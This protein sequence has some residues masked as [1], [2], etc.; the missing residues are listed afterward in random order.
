MASVDTN[1]LL[2]WILND[3]PEQSQ[4]VDRLFDSGQQFVVEDAAIIE[5]VLCLNVYWV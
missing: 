5:T 2:R 4:D 1:I 3:I